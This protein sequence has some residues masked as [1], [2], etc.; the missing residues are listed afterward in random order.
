ME[1][2]GPSVYNTARCH[3][4]GFPMRR[5]LLFILVSLICISPAQVRAQEDTPS[6]KNDGNS[7]FEK[8][9]NSQIEE[10]QRYYRACIGNE[11]LSTRKNCKCATTRYLEARLE[12]GSAVSIDAILD[13][14]SGTC[15]K[16]EN[17]APLKNPAMSKITDKQ[18]AEAIDVY[19]DCRVNPDLRDHFKCDCLASHFLDKR[20]EHGPFVGRGQIISELGNE[21][22][23][24]TQKT[25]KA[26]TKCIEK[27]IF[28]DLKNVEK[29]VYCECKAREFGKIYKDYTKR[30]D[31][32][33]E[34][35]IE[36]QA[37]GRCRK[38]LLY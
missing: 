29:S 30:I 26:Y 32:R 25:G 16:G 31:S 24:V 34:A 36:G 1:K 14:I 27:P 4:I 33:S 35:L 37:A 8:A 10:A 23:N 7:V 38:S 19:Q 18:K 11:T 12:M 28:F 17:T 3:K 13:R 21:C 22:R 5:F 15:M 9:S 2:K 20:I 6:N